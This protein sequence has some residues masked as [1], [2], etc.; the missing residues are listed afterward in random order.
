MSKNQ[1][2]VVVCLPCY[3]AELFIKRTLESLKK[4]TY[5][6]FKVFVSDDKSTDQTVSLIKSLVGTDERFQLIEQ[7]QNLGWIDNVDFLLEKAASEGKY[8][9][10]MPHDDVIESSYIAKLVEALENNPDA[11]LS[12][13]DMNFNDR[14]PSKVASYT[15]MGKVKSRLKR[16]EKLLEKEKLWWIA[17]RGLMRAD[18]I[19]EIIPSQKNL[20]GNREYA[21]DWFLLIRLAMFGEFVRVPEVLYTKYYHENNKSHSFKHNHLN[22]FGN[23]ATVFVMIFRSPLRWSEML[24]LQLKIL[25]YAAKRVII[26]SGGYKLGKKIHSLF[27]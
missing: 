16:L 10:I 26:M 3:N 12:F 27:N 25:E 9:F 24:Y 2:K 22:Y 7:K 8:T 20:F 4:Q 1:P 5:S 19:P 11:V 17:Y 6:N 15:A 18:L 21:A 23:L 13:S 14:N